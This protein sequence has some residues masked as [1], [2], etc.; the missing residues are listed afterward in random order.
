MVSA[1]KLGRRL[2]AIGPATSLYAA[3]YQAFKPPGSLVTTV[4]EH[5]LHLD[6]GDLGLARCL[7]VYDGNWEPLETE[8]FLWIV[9]KNMVVLDIG[10]NVGYY[11]LLAARAVGASG[12][13]YAFEPAPN[14]YALLCQNIRDN[15]YTN[16][17]TIPKAV[18]DRSGKV[19]LYLDP[20]N[21]GSHNLSGGATTFASVEVEAAALDE[22]FH[23][24]E[25]PIDV[26][27]VDAEGAEA[28]ILQGMRDLLR[29]NAK[30]ALF[31]EFHPRAMESLGSSPEA[32][33]A[34]LTQLGFNMFMLDEKD[35][36]LRSLH[37]MDVGRLVCVI[38][39]GQGRDHVD[40][41]CV[42]GDW[43]ELGRFRPR[44]KTLY[45]S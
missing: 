30:L 43:P 3:L 25:D 28:L 1:S 39:D 36:I 14:N 18:A 8:L 19:R 5:Q 32:Y 45:G 22:Y 12:K 31:T 42:R 41:L 24:Y 7:L 34:Q 16:V 23:G 26:I 4:R 35:Q 6:P 2:K 11:T 21:L 15:G 33:I 44:D 37:P 20:K 29:R 10:A 13:V 40:L 17:V 9:K 27:K 38:K